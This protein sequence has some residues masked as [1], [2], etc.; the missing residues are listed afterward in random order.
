MGVGT[1]PAS[2]A[3]TPAA[4]SPEI[5]EYFTASLDVLVS[6]PTTEEVCK[7]PVASPTS[8]IS[9]SRFLSTMSLMPEEPKSLICLL[10]ITA[11]GVGF[12]PTVPV[13]R[14]S[15]FQ[16]RHLKP[17]GHPSPA[18]DYTVFGL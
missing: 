3:E 18:S 17:L 9:W 12:E 5:K 1:I 11:E 8:N 6:Q 2:A 14:D 16:D 13:T 10:K 7:L 15:G 4:R